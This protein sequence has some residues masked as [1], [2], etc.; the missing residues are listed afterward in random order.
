MSA[1]A[2]SPRIYTL[3]E[4]ERATSTPSF[5]SDLIDAIAAAFAQYSSGGFNACPIQTMGAPPM[6]RLSC[7]SDD[8]YAAQVC[9]K[10]GY[11]TGAEHFVVKVAAGGHPMPNTG[12]MQVFSQRSGA[13]EALLLDDG[14]LTEMRTAAAGALAARCLG[15]RSLRRIGV[16]GTGIQARF[17]LRF[18][19]AVTDCREVLIYGRTAA[20]AEACRDEWRAEGWDV[21]L[22]SHPDELLRTCGLI[23]C[24]TS[25]REPLLGNVIAEGGGKFD[26]G[27]LIVCIGADAPGKIEVGT[28]LVASADLLVADS[29]LQTEERGEYEKVISEGLVSLSDVVEIGEVLQGREECQRKGAED[30]RLIIFDSSGVAVQD[31]VIADMVYRAMMRS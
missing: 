8:R 11:V 12:C 13:L 26:G 5:R 9:V 30:D 1:G 3:P 27:Q 31:C 22:A 17:Q 10:S 18:L 7:A 6:A 4:I 20:S 23:V 29:R 25:S 19:R 15:P 28:G 16:L 2:T 21:S 14:V 24:V